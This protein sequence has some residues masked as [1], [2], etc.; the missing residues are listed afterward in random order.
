M[1][2]QFYFDCPERDLLRT[3]LSALKH[4][5]TLGEGRGYAAKQC[6][7]FTSRR[8]DELIERLSEPSTGD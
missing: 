8:I 4:L 5:G 7:T 1:K 2:R 6:I 3:A